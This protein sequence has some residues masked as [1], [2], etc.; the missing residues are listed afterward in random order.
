M[1]T[2]KL[3]YNFSQPWT[4]FSSM[5]LPEEALR[6]RTTWDHRRIMAN[7]SPWDALT[8]RDGFAHKMV[9]LVD[10]TRHV[11]HPHFGTIW[12][13]LAK[14][15]KPAV[16]KDRKVFPNCQAQL[17]VRVTGNGFQGKSN[18]ERPNI[19]LRNPSFMWAQLNHKY[20]NIII[21][22]PQNIP[23]ISQFLWVV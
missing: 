8:A 4:H 3:G 19:W 18:S 11:I 7:W 20:Q 9:I 17:A 15:Q 10:R 6:W 22:N 5:E 16:L 21:S 12:E 13:S 1:K 23:K 14:S 2:Y